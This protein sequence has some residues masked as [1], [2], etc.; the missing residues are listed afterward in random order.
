MHAILRNT[1][2]SFK[3]DISLPWAYQLGKIDKPVSPGEF[4]CLPLQC[5]NNSHV[6]LFRVYL[7]GLT[8]SNSYLCSNHFTN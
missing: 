5:G 1:V 7:H 2:S 4:S 3:T 6:P 8:R